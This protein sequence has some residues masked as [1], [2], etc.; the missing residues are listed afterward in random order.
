MFS[1]YCKNV[2][3]LSFGVKNNH[4]FKIHVWLFLLEPIKIAPVSFTTISLHIDQK[5]FESRLCSD[6][7][8]KPLPQLQSTLDASQPNT[9]TLMSIL[10]IPIFKIFY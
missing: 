9:N 3:H 4:Y 8:P 6:L 1:A 5:H 7:N 2:S 10:E